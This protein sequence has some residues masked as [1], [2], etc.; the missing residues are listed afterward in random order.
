MCLLQSIGRGQRPDRELRMSMRKRKE[1]RSREFG[2]KEEEGET[3]EKTEG[4]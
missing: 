1:R 3:I 4:R 2:E